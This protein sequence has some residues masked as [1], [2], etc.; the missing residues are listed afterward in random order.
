MKITNPIASIKQCSLGLLIGT[1]FLSTAAIATVH[2]LK[3][4]TDSRIEVVA[5][6]PYNVVPIQGTTFTTT[7]ITFSK[8][9]YI[10]N[11]QNGDL[12][13]WTASI[14]KSI[15]NM[16]FVKPTVYSSNTNMTVVTNKHTYY[17][18]LSSNAK[19]EASQDEATYAIHFVY[20]EAQKKKVE[21]EILLREQQKQAELSA[22]KNPSDYNWNYSYS[23][24]TSIMP[25]HVFDD[26]K[27]T[28]MQ[29]RSNQP[30]PAVFSVTSPSGA[31]SVVNY[32]QDG[33]YIVIQRVAPQFTLRLG[34]DHVASV[35]NTRMISKL[36][37]RG[38][39]V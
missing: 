34:K 8:N 7:Q 32:R 6:S 33:Q 19:G 28:Y 29:L 36:R 2:P 11:V 14:N 25:I 3:L 30:E 17:F 20:P 37:S 16:M 26:G 21:Q 27:F 9:E 15:P 4:S 24:D 13:A 23:G 35:F 10:E 39:S 1:L 12:G 31:E 5:F 18:H 38:Y 22:F